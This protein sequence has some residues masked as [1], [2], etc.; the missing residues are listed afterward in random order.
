M[1]R[2]GREP[3]ML[4]TARHEYT[5][6]SALWNYADW[7]KLPEENFKY[8]WTSCNEIVTIDERQAVLMIYQDI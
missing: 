4:G 7:Q 6:P 3:R 5:S 8:N 1:L 2:S